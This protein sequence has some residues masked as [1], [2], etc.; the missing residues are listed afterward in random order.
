MKKKIKKITHKV[1]PK[2]KIIKS[3]RKIK[4]YRNINPI[5]IDRNSPSISFGTLIR[6]EKPETKVLI[7]RVFQTYY[8]NILEKLG[9]LDIPIWQ[10]AEM[11]KKAVSVRKNLGTG[12]KEFSNNEIIDLM[13]FYD[14]LKTLPQNL[15][16]TFPALAIGA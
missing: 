3:S 9:Y 16:I 4:P 6:N 7:W 5:S 8:Y 11:I 14:E 1:K 10:F 15:T 12:P 13:N 2:R